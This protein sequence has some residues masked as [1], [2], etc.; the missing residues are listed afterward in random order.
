MRAPKGR[1][2]SAAPASPHG[3]PAIKPNGKKIQY[4]CWGLSHKPDPERPYYTT[5]DRPSV[6]LSNINKHLPA[7]EKLVSAHAP[8]AAPNGSREYLSSN[9][10]VK[11]LS[12]VCPVGVQGK[13]SRVVFRGFPLA[14]GNSLDDK[15]YPDAETGRLSDD[16]YGWPVKF[17]GHRGAYFAT[18]PNLAVRYA[19]GSVDGQKFNPDT[20]DAYLV[21]YEIENPDAHVCGEF[22]TDFNIC[23]R[24]G[25]S[26]ANAAANEKLQKENDRLKEEGKYGHFLH[27]EEHPQLGREVFLHPEV[28]LRLHKIMRVEF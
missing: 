16:S 19:F 4:G 6:K 28:K 27:Y 18:T 22:E 17:P 2:K 5:T 10:Q 15:T 21:A 7:D 13:T 25:D 14:K 23:L 20:T 11:V 12:D 9:A 3:F 1:S 26:D 24:P 8:D